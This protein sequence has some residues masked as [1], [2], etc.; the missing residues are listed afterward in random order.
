MNKNEIAVLSEKQESDLVQAVEK[1]H[2]ASAMKND[3]IKSLRLAHGMQQLKNVLNS[4][5]VKSLIMSFQN[6]PFGFLTDR[7]NG[8]EEK[9]VLNC[10]LTA[11]VAGAFLHGFQHAFPIEPHYQQRDQQSEHRR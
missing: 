1:C 11:L 4:P 2:I 10:S 3:T 9:T 5:E 8:Y 6:M 7:D